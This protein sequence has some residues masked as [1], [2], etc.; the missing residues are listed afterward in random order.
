MKTKLFLVLTLLLLI[1]C[2]SSNISLANDSSFS[3]TPQSG[4]VVPLEN[5]A[6]QMYSEEITFINNQFVTIFVF[7]NNTNREQQVTMG[8]PVV[9]EFKENGD[10]EYD[11]QQLLAKLTPTERRAYQLQKIRD[12]Y[13]FKSFVN[14]NEVPRTLSEL[15]GSAYRFAFLTPL[16]FAPNESLI[17]TNIYHQE[18]NSSSNVTGIDNNELQYIFKSGALWQGKIARANFHFYLD[19]NYHRFDKVYEYIPSEYLPNKD[20]RGQ[21]N[22]FYI[23]AQPQ[24][25]QLSDDGRYFSCQWRFTEIEPNTEITVKWGIKIVTPDLK[26]LAALNV[27]INQKNLTGLDQRYNAFFTEMQDRHTYNDYTIALATCK[28]Q[29][30]FKPGVKLSARFLI[31]SIYAL[32]GYRFT[33]PEWSGF[34]QLF[35]WYQPQTDKPIFTEQENGL[36]KGLLKLEAGE[37]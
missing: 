1:A 12:Y 34:Y 32:K 14:G 5:K 8:F 25:T 30:N 6:I 26:T 22:R 10:A 35:K 9:G 37:G 4:N 28:T 15:S 17:V 7:K 31:N 11:E 13:Q 27:A 21:F 2:F 20:Y 16:K 33:S 3:V 29:G 24:M 23:E 36:I 19:N 18:P